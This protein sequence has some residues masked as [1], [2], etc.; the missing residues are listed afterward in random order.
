MGVGL[1]NSQWDGMTNIA[2]D[3]EKFLHYLTY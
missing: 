1:G 2:M 3:Q